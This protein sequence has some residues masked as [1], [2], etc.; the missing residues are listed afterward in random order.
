[1][2]LQRPDR[3]AFSY[4]K[5]QETKPELVIDLTEYEISTRRAC[6]IWVCLTEMDKVKY[7]FKIYQNSTNGSFLLNTMTS[8]G[9]R[10]TDETF[11]QK[12]TTIWEN[13]I[14]GTE[15]T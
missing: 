14:I 1:M 4:I 12:R 15:N 3:R 6:G 9:T 11:K 2:K 8:K 10:F 13:K 5:E 7:L